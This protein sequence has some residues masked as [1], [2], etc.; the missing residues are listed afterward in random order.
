MLTDEQWVVL[1][2]LV[3]PCRPHA[4]VPPSNLRRT[5]SA[6]LWRHANGAKWRSIPAELGPW[7]MAAQI[8]IRRWARLGVW[9]RLL[10]L[11]QERGVQLGM[12]FL[13]G[14]SVRAASQGRR[15][16]GQK[17]R[18]GATRRK[19]S[20][21]PLSWR[22]W[23]QGLRDRGRRRA[24]DRL[25]ARRPGRR[26]SCRTPCRCWTHCP[27]SHAGWSRIG[28]TAAMA[29]ASMSGVW[30]P[31]RPFRPRS[32]KHPCACPRWVYNNRHRVERLW[33]RLKEWP[34]VATRYEKTARSFM[35]V[36]CL[37]AALDSLRR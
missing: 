27:G 10:V 30:A 16:R 24:S 28:A 7:W 14:T 31:A 3:E 26:T 32:A 4:K 20:A 8:F 23:H 5:I 33:A 13:D 6:I 17:R 9:E 2:P 36:L 18:P 25:S 12:T 21:W 19:R 29:F 34:A 11:A 22:L 35:G 15:R 37:A 1:E